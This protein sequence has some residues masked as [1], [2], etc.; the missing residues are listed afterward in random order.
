[1]ANSVYDITNPAT[2]HKD[3]TIFYIYAEFIMKD[4]EAYPVKHYSG[5]KGRQTTKAVGK[6]KNVAEKIDEMVS[7]DILQ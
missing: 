1:M 4:G 5:I 3:G 7:E 6:T 2:K